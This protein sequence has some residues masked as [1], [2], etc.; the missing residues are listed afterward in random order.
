MSS[1]RATHHYHHCYTD[2]LQCLHEKICGREA[3][4]SEIWGISFSTVTTRLLT[5]LSLQKFLATNKMT[6]IAHPP[7]S[8][9]LAP[10]D[11]LLFP[12]LKIALK[13]R[14]FNDTNTVQTKLWDALAEFQNVHFTQFFEQW[15]DRGA[16][17]MKSYGDCFEGDSIDWRQVLPSC[18]NILSP[19]SIWSHRVKVHNRTWSTLQCESYIG[20]YF[21]SKENPWGMTDT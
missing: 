16:H 17:G 11:F 18:G 10:C 2:A 1:T 15:H 8:S 14:R 19:K 3:Q 6:V 21:R 20:R 5:A 9:H 12:Q 4:K 7:Y 13:G